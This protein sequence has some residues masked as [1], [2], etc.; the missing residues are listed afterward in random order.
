MNWAWIEAAGGLEPRFVT[1]LWFSGFF[2]IHARI[3]VQHLLDGVALVW[4]SKS[5]NGS[6]W[7]TLLVLAIFIS[8]ISDFY[9]SSFP[10]HQTYRYGEPILCRGMVVVLA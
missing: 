3:G 6:V 2:E 4:V 1:L 7:A 8:G 10:L 9:D 5:G